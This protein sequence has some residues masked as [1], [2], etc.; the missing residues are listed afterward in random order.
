MSPIEVNLHDVTRI[1]T[2]RH[3]TNT[4]R[5]KWTTIKFV[6]VGGQVL[7]EVTA[8]H[9]SLEQ[10]PDQVGQLSPTEHPK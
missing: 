7:L 2:E 4:T 5:T 6:G 9:G 3:K 8:F 1:E 10:W